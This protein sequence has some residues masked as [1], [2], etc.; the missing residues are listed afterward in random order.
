MGIAGLVAVAG[1]TSAGGAR[2]QLQPAATLPP[3][4]PVA[5][6]A[7]VQAAD[8]ALADTLDS[9]LAGEEYERLRS[10]VI[11]SSGRTVYERYFHSAPTAQHEVFS[12]TKSLTGILMG[13]AIGEGLIDGVDETL[14]SLLPD[15]AAGM[16]PEVAQATL[17]QVLTERAGLSDES[18]VDAAE[19]TGDWVGALLANPVAAPGAGFHYSD[20]SLTLL[21]AILVRV[22]GRSVLAYAREKLFDP[23]GIVLSPFAQVDAWQRAGSI[24][25]AGIGVGIYL[26][27]SDIGSSGLRLTGQDMAKLGLLML[28]DGRWE[29]R[30]VVPA[31]WVRQATTTHADTGAFQVGYGYQWWTGRTSEGDPTFYALGAGQQTILVVPD[32]QLVVAYQ[33]W[34]P[35]S[36]DAPVGALV[37]EL[38]ATTVPPALAR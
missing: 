22:T 28:Q 20:A 38:I 18:P 26:Q 12:V 4:L 3:L 34:L 23:L 19:Q 32:R 7:N 25:G 30:Q 9:E 11:L 15:R 21:S 2:G 35:E 17:E 16:S 31:Q 36:G 27:G 33:L 5:A 29:G 8:A 13:I 37:R 24:D 14:A 1:C 10:L 6:Q